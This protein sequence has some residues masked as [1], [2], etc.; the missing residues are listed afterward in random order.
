MSK[1]T[2][3]NLRYKLMQTLEDRTKPKNTIYPNNSQGKD[4][5][6]TK[7]QIDKIM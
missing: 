7:E 3:E 4:V 6:D 1:D 5:K 2:E